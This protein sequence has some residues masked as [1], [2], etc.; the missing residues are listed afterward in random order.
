[1]DTFCWQEQ[2][3]DLARRLRAAGR[4]D[5]RARL[6]RICKT[7]RRE[8]CEVRIEYDGPCSRLLISQPLAGEIDAALWPTP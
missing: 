3:A 8:S 1:M 7:S 5:L 4:E 2:E 6:I